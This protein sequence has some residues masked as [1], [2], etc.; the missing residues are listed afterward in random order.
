MKITN[1]FQTTSRT[2]W[3]AW[4]RRHAKV[5]KDVWLIYYRKGSGHTRISYNDAVEEAL[6]FGW[7]DSTVKT[8]DS[9]RVAQRFSPRKPGSA[10]SQTNQERLIR[11]ISQRKVT[12][13]VLATLGNLNPEAFTIPADIRRALETSPKAWENFQRYSPSYQRIRAAYV[14]SG[15]RRPGQFQKRLRH[16]VAMTEKNKQF[17]FGIETYY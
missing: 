15:R 7:I 9:Q 13:D 5:E 6:C 3:R 8:Y 1:T 2:A 14:D 12:K 11:L 16:L 10:V 17:G 4:L